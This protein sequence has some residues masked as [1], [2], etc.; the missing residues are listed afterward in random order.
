MGPPCPPTVVHVAKRVCCLKRT[1]GHI[2][3]LLIPGNSLYLQRNSHISTSVGS[4]TICTFCSAILNSLPLLFSKCTFLF[5][6]FGT[7]TCV[8]TV[9]NLERTLY[10]P[11]QPS[12]SSPRIHLTLGHH[13]ELDFD[14]TSPGS[15]LACPARLGV[16][17]CELTFQ[18]FPH[19]NHTIT[20]YCHSLLLVITYLIPFRGLLRGYGCLTHNCVLRDLASCPAHIF[21]ERCYGG[22]LGIEV[23]PEKY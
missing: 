1:S 5:V 18:H 21:A 12:S 7:Y 16:S 3:P 15:L 23:R 9:W 14:A 11:S 2:A 13:S 20:L 4:A 6:A 10:T 8:P 22:T 17:L 19:D